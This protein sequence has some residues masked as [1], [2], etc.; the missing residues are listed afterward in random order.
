MRGL[1]R[2]IDLTI[3]TPVPSSFQSKPPTPQVEQGGRGGAAV[4]GWGGYPLWVSKGYCRRSG[5]RHATWH[6]THHPS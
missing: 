1:P 4:G 3:F 5:E 6:A 2:S